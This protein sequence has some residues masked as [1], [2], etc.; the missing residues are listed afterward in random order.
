M[1]FDWVAEIGSGPVVDLS[2]EIQN[3][4]SKDFG[5]RRDLGMEDSLAVEILDEVSS[6]IIDQDIAPETCS[7][8]QEEKK[9]SVEMITLN[10]SSDYSVQPAAELE[11]ESLM[12]LAS[13]ES[14]KPKILAAEISITP[15]SNGNG[16][17]EE[18][19]LSKANAVEAEVP[20]FEAESDESEES[21]KPEI[22][23]VKPLAEI[24]VNDYA[25]SEE[26]CLSKDNAVKYEVSNF[27]SESEDNSSE[28]ESE[29]SEASDVDSE[30]YVASEESD[31]GSSLV[32]VNVDKFESKEALLETSL[33]VQAEEKN[34]PCL[35]EDDNSEEES[36]E[37]E[38]SNEEECMDS[39]DDVESEE[40]DSEASLVDVNVDKLE[41]LSL[42][43][44]EENNSPHQSGAKIALPVPPFAADQLSGQFPRPTLPTPSKSSSKKNHPVIQMITD[45]LDENEEEIDGC[46]NDN[47]ANKDKNCSDDNNNNFT[48]K[49]CRDKSLRQ[50]Q[51]MLKQ[52]L[53]IENNKKVK[54]R[55][56]SC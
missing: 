16:G 4:N 42:V 25:G 13:E 33:V 56:K 19:S 46:K 22:L 41:T 43:Q 26:G 20:S 50:L 54:A 2:V 55:S 18:E 15:A 38:A 45:A 32:D 37:S 12:N 11:S 17:S 52:K 47:E 31:S 39:D 5:A 44:A 3:S 24:L 49:L 30:D 10:P 21:F 51:K 40:S 1:T 36:A 35:S 14:S 23:T 8:R 53:Q 7:A 9:E 27:E 48:M 34:S 6:G 28:E 29:E